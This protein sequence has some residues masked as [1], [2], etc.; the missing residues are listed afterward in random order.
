MRDNKL[1]IQINKPVEEVFAFTLDPKNTPRWIDDSAKEETSEWPV[2]PGTIYKNTGKNGVVLTFIMRELVPNDY[3]E[4]TSDDGKYH[5][6]YTFRDLGNN[7][8]EY[9]YHE[10][11]DDGELEYV[12]SREV[13][14]K[15][16]TVLENPQP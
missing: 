16:K 8:T 11:Q 12:M 1:T 15:L 2:K 4:L 14:E 6:R 13:I 5:C 7:T 9:E 10:W 3:F